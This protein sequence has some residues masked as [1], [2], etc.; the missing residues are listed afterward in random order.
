M[1]YIFNFATP[2][3]QIRTYSSLNTL[4][5]KNSYIA[6][7]I[8]ITTLYITISINRPTISFRLLFVISAK[9]IVNTLRKIAPYL[10]NIII[11]SI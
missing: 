9:A 11:F 1:T 6:L 5:D 3:R 10:A 2:M 8:A 7:M 4:E